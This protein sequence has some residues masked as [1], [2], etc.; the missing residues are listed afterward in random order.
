MY[1]NLEAQKAIEQAG[2]GSELRSGSVVAVRS[3][4]LGRCLK[5]VGLVHVICMQYTLS[6]VLGLSMKPWRFSPR[7]H[8]GGGA[9]GAGVLAQSIGRS[10]RSSSG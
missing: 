8:S 6:D 7:L 4:L 3:L 9:A 2:S 5:L 1:V 10:T